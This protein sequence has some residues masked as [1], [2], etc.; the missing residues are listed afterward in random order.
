[1]INSKLIK[2]LNIL[3]EDYRI[4]NDGKIFNSLGFALYLSEVY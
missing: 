4:N 3:N 1:M 2:K